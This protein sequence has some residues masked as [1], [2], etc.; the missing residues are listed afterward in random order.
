MSSF[1]TP[2]RSR[3][4]ACDVTGAPFRVGDLVVVVAA[5]DETC[6]KR[7]LGKSGRVVY[8]EYSCGCGQTY[9][10][11]PMIGVQFAEGTQEE[12]WREEI[13]LLT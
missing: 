11:D 10:Y 3:P 13:Q 12:F 9:P 6:A 4:L 7:C 2:K 8:F 5:S 1:T